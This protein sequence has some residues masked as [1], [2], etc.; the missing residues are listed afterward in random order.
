MKVFVI[1]AYPYNDRINC[2]AT[3][4]KESAKDDPYKV[5]QFVANPENADI[6]IFAEHHLGFDPYYFEVLKSKIY[7]TFKKK[8]Y[9]YHDNP[10]SLAL[11]PTVSP[12]VRARGF[13]P[14]FNQPYNYLT[15]IEKNR[16]LKQYT[17]AIEKKYLFSFIGASRTSPIRKKIL[18]LNFEKSYLLDTSDKN[19]WELN[20]SE[21]DNYYKHFAQICLESKFVL[22][23]RG[24]GPNSYRLYEC[25]EMGVAPVIISDDW[26]ETSGPVWND[27]SIRVSESDIHKIPEILAQREHESDKMG[28]LARKAWTDW[29]TKDKQFHHL[30]EACLAL[31]NS[32]SKISFMTYVFQYLKF[33]QPY[34]LKNLSRYYRNIFKTQQIEFFRQNGEPMKNWVPT[35][36][37]G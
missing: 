11:M 21:K 34:H 36:D 30:T 32:R 10:K 25:L 28:E 22:C 13:N 17:S 19:S 15:Q 27:F 16:Y 6:I 23:P 31:H 3:Y 9:L 20:G 33:L 26:I 14:V 37:V 7:K 29:F 12:S 1:S 2:A 35:G 8:C 24:I 18:S 5:H 4:L